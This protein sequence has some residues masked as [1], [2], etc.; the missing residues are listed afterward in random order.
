MALP[1][2][3]E[4]MD[5]VPPLTVS[6]RTLVEAMAHMPDDEVFRWYQ[7]SYVAPNGSVFPLDTLRVTLG[8]VRSELGLK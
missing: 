5:D 6:L 1:N 3:L 4:P 7:K 8:Q 2:E